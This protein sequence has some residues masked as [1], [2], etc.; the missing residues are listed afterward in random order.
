MVHLSDIDK[1]RKH[2]PSGAYPIVVQWLR[3]NP[4]Q[5]SIVRPRQTKLGD[6]RSAINGKPHRVTVNNDLNKYS[7]LVTLIHEF[8]HYTTCVNSKRWL[9]PHG[10][11]WKNEYHRLMRPFMSRS[12]FPADVLKALEHHLYDAP[13]SSCTDIDLMRVL[14]KYDREPRPMLEELEDRSVFRFNEKIFVKGPQ[15]RRRYKCHCLNDRRLYFIDPLAE[16][17]VHGPMIARK[18]S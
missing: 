1:L 17:H 7:F 2:I 6:Y 16:V 8:A 14:R 13:A 18:A 11:K 4:L 10:T 5:L 9:Q 15:M 3:R 12:V